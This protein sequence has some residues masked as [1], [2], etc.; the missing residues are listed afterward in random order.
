LGFRYSL[1]GVAAAE[2]DA[3]IMLKIIQITSRILK[4]LLIR[5]V[6]V[7]L[8]KYICVRT[9]SESHNFG[10]TAKTSLPRTIA[11]LVYI[12]QFT[13]FVSRRIMSLSLF[14]LYEKSR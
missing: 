8:L 10:S 3:G 2:T 6:I 14:S 5:F 4:S 12:P 7:D 13:T 11:D 1:L 9:E